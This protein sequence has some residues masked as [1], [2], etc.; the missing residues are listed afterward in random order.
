MKYKGK[1]IVILNVNNRIGKE[2]ADDIA[3]ARAKIIGV[4]KEP[5]SRGLDDELSMM[6]GVE[7]Q[8]ISSD[9][10]EETPK[11]V[12]Q[13]VLEKTDKIDYLFIIYSVHNYDSIKSYSEEMN[14]RVYDMSDLGIA[15]G[16]NMRDTGGGSVFII[17]DLDDFYSKN[18]FGKT[19][20]Q[21]TFRHFKDDMSLIFGKLLNVYDLYIGKC[22]SVVEKLK[23]INE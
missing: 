12:L 17:A 21:N 14:S 18:P 1:N 19:V 4:G 16:A 8:Y 3:N 9:I 7:L 23:E 13:K 22:E 5:T 6:Y 2:I 15:F 20:L 11:E 10:F